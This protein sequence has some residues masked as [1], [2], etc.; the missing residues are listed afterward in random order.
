M[1][2]LVRA[3]ATAS[4][5]FSSI[6]FAAD[7]PRQPS[8]TRGTEPI[9]TLEKFVTNGNTDDTIGL[10]DK[11]PTDS[12][13]GFKKTL[14]ETPRSVTTL[15]DDLMVAYGIESALD[16]TK[17]APSTFTTSIFGINGNVNVRGIPSDTYF[18][19]VKR[20]E[21]TQ[22]FPSPITAMS[23]LEVVRGPPSPIYGPGKVGGYTNFVPKSARASTGKYLESPTGK[24]V[25]TYG[26]YNKKVASFEIGGP[27]SIA[28]KRGGYF[29]Y[30]NAE[31]S[32]TYYNNVYY[33]QYII[34]SSFDFEVTPT[35]RLEFGQMYQYWG[36]TELAGWNRLTQELIDTGMY[37]AGEVALNMDRD[38]DGFISTAEVNSYGPL[39]R[40]IAPGTSPAAAAAQFGPGWQVDPT[41]VGKVKLSRHANSQSPEDGGQANINLAYFDAV[42]EPSPETKL[43]NKIYAENINRF[44]WTRASGYGQSTK[45]FV[46][47]EKLVLEKALSP[48]SE[49]FNAN[50]SLAG[51]WRYYDTQNLTG[52]QYNDLVNRADISRP[53][54]IKNRFAVPNLEP[55]LAPWAQGI[56]SNYTTTGIGGLFDATFWK[57]TNVILGGRGDWVSIYSRIPRHVITTPGLEA[58]NNENGFSWSASVSQEIAKGIRPYYTY[59]KQ[60]TLVVGIDGSIGVGAVPTALNGSELREVGI[61][62]NLFNNRL[63]AAVSGYRQTRT[64]F[65][66]D[67]G[68]VLATLSRGAELEIRWVA[69]KRLSFTGGGTWQKT[70]YSPVRAST[71]SV[72]PTFFGLPDNYYGGRVQTTLLAQ[73][74]YSERSGYPDKVITLNGTY[75]LKGGWSMNLS[76]RYQASVPSGRIKDI[77]LPQAHVYGGGLV[78]D[79][80]RWGVRFTVN[81]LTNELYFTPNSPDGLG[82]VIVIP[83]AERHYQST[84]TYKF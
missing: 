83:A 39:L 7:A 46:F 24:A 19:G 32:D 61:K 22:L 10:L 69:S 29:V 48:K 43:T 55:H 62:G 74:D 68:Q 12:I 73:T 18:R 77:T 51:N 75:I 35:V 38:G 84:F 28:G 15:S 64:S 37:N 71:I 34:Q 27:F 50:A 79:A 59:S 53:F 4:L 33:D 2:K 56:R 5:F 42:F 67:T 78:Y 11:E 6:A 49:W 63:F 52:T 81:N 23:R 26:S 1:S 60:E 17:L 72:N 14:L 21:N 36:G 44:K 80:K 47:E 13:F 30:L 40:T 66:Q 54:S 57:K 3:L 16:V 58:K 41:T 65:S 20:L 82:E 70:I 31:N 45:T 9:V 8:D 25:V 76:G